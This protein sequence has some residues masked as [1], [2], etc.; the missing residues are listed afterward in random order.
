V[1][2]CFGSVVVAKLSGIVPPTHGTNSPPQPVVYSLTGDVGHTTGVLSLHD[3]LSATLHIARE[4]DLKSSHADVS[5][6]FSEP[7]FI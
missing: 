7:Y 5:Y 6:Y 4:Q 2:L 1:K 3:L